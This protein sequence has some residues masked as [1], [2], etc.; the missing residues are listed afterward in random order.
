MLPGPA[1]A[2]ADHERGDEAPFASRWVNSVRVRGGLRRTFQSAEVGQGTT[3]R[4]DTRTW[5]RAQRV[6]PVALHDHIRE[7]EAVALDDLSG[8]DATWT[9]EHGIVVHEGVELP[10][11]AARIGARGKV[12]D[13]PRVQFASGEGGVETNRP[14][15]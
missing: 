2:S 4:A 7:H 14:C 3:S 12:V 6:L 8:S 9:L 11:F 15:C 13:Q 10:A 1:S 5:R